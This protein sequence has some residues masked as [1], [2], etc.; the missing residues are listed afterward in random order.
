[1]S[2]ERYLCL[3]ALGDVVTVNI[4]VPSAW[5]RTENARINFARR[6]CFGFNLRA[7]L[8]RLIN[9]LLPLLCYL[10]TDFT[11]PNLQD[12]FARRVCIQKGSI[13]RNSHDGVGVFRGKSGQ[14]Q[15]FLL[16]SLAI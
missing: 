16:C 10:L 2:F 4:D 1:M 5:D 6:S 11:V 12:F 13:L 9:V 15:N 3:F 8:K 14:A 7:R